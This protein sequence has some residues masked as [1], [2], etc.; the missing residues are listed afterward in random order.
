MQRLWDK[1]LSGR[2]LLTVM[3]G[4]VFMYC[5]FTGK[6]PADKVYDVI[7]VIIVA[8]FLKGQNNNPKGA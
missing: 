8:Y 5:S 1:L 4:I 2:F 3:A 7:N 6:I